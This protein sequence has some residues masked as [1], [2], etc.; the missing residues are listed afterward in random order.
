MNVLIAGGAGYVGTVLSNT[1]INQN[2]K[3]TVVDNLWFGNHLD[4]NVEVIKKD[5]LDI[6]SEDLEGKD[7]VIFMAGLSNDPMANF[8]PQ[9]NFIENSAVPTYLAFLCKQNNIPR[10]VYASSCSVYG[11]TD[12]EIMT[13]NSVTK[14]MY[15]YGISKLQ[16][17]YSIMKMKD[18][19]FRPICLRSGTIGGWS[20]RMRFDLVVNTMV[21]SAI[22]N[23]KLLVHN[24]NLWRP[25]I[26]VQ[27]VA[28]AYIKCLTC[29]SNV[30]EVFN[31]S[32][33][34]YTIGGLA[35]QIRDELSQ[36]NIKVDIEEQ[37]VKDVRNYLACN[38]KIRDILG[39]IPKK[40][41]KD[42]VH[43]IMKNITNIDIDNDIY[44]NINIFKKLNL[45]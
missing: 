29:E 3:V 43:D 32:Q 15:P 12:N 26:D 27:D 10:F 21:K 24:P 9:R 34:N 16:A 2:F 20:K 37:N 39:F 28:E 31:I 41:P 23:N 22:K 11:F 7:A 36:W 45:S 33:D 38:R 19:N 8:S 14:P 44:Y 5:I 17:E 18:S 1:L 25:L 35:K 13:E 40:K 4:S 6:A 42:S 30:S